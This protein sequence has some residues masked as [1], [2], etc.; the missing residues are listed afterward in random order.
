MADSIAVVVTSDRPQIV[1]TVLDLL[2][3]ALAM[4][5]E[6]HVYFTG[7]SI[8]FVGRPGPAGSD[9]VG[10]EVRSEV[11]ERLRSMKAEGDLHVYACTR[12]MKAHDIAPESL[13]DEVDMPAGFVYFLNL[14]EGAKVTFSF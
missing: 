11:T 3:A 1:R 2:D 5:S 14:A 8:G 4:E 13:A 7:E 6:A 12:A 9:V 10:D